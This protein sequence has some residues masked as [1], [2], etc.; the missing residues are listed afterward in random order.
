MPHGVAF[1][2]IDVAANSGRTIEEC[3][4]IC[5]KFADKGFLRRFTR[6]EGVFYNHVPWLQGVSELLR[7]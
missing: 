1:K 2:A 6:D 5:E 7:Q 4:E 3:A